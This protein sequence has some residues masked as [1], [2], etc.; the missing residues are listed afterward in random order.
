ML[1]L[2]Q[3]DDHEPAKPQRQTEEEE[4]E[5]EDAYILGRSSDVDPVLEG[6]ALSSSSSVED[7]RQKNEQTQPR[8]SDNDVV[9]KETSGEHDDDKESAQSSKKPGVQ[10]L[11]VLGTATLGSRLQVCGTPTN[12]T[13][14]CLFQ[15]LRYDARRWRLWRSL[16]QIVSNKVNPPRGPTHCEQN[17][18]WINAHGGAGANPRSKGPN[19]HSLSRRRRLSPGCEVPAYGSGRAKRRQRCRLR[20]GWPASCS[21]YQNGGDVGESHARGYIEQDGRSHLCSVAN[22]KKGM[23]DGGSV[24][25]VY[26]FAFF[27]TIRYYRHF[28]G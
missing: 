20:R 5:E 12:G 16:L 2:E 3:Q 26:I 25:S 28:W 13:K 17:Q 10:D 7:Q 8:P 22:R 19:V 15:W 6:H 4:E 9:G 1:Q 23:R 14:L 27:F 24:S 18:A 11:E 21:R